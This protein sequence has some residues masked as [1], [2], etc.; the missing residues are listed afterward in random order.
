MMN[1]VKVGHTVYAPC[2]DGSSGTGFVLA[3]TVISDKKF[4]LP[5]EGEHMR[6]C[7]RWWLNNHIKAG[8]VKVYQSRRKALMSLK[9]KGIKVC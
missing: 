1:L 2:V 4:T 3:L 5:A 9:L 7:M 6:F 8:M